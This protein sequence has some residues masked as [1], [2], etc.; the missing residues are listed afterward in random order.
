VNNNRGPSVPK[1]SQRKRSARIR[2]TQ[3][4]YKLTRIA[5][6]DKSMER[7]EGQITGA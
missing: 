2:Q 3:G 4:Y 6:G 1:R 5:R 7:S